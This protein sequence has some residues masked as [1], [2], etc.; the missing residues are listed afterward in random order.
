MP[1]ALPRNT[2]AKGMAAQTR[3]R[4]GLQEELLPPPSGVT[5]EE[6]APLGL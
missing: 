4:A 3:L 1:W 2:P 6:E 5:W